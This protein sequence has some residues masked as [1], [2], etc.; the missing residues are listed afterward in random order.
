MSLISTTFSSVMCPHFRPLPVQV[1]VSWKKVVIDTAH[2]T[3][4][5]RGFWYPS[6]VCQHLAAVLCLQVI[7]IYSPRLQHCSTDFIWTILIYT[8]K[9]QRIPFEHAIWI[10]PS[11]FQVQSAAT[12]SKY[13]NSTFQILFLFSCLFINA[14][15]E[16]TEKRE[17]LHHLSFWQNSSCLGKKVTYIAFLSQNDS[18]LYSH[19]SK[20]IGKC[21]S[22]V[23]LATI[24]KITFKNGVKCLLILS[25][26]I[27]LYFFSRPLVLMMLCAQ[28]FM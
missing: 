10:L 3:A 25:L 18:F 24:V 22:A 17:F 2:I 4:W 21:T 7:S 28:E 26:L 20:D 15:Q 23:E 11:T 5:E 6:M 14:C 13:N 8:C 1:T 19:L 27:D 9:Y 12:V 16:T